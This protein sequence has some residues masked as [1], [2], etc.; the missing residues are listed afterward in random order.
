MIPSALIIENR[1]KTYQL[2]GLVMSAHVTLALGAKRISCF[3]YP[4]T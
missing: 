2:G 1:L 4:K 3:R